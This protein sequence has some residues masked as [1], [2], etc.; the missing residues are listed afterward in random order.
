MNES[1]EII[2]KMVNLDNFQ[3]NRVYAYCMKEMKVRN[4]KTHAFEVRE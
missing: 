1:N 2:E 3:L 4:L